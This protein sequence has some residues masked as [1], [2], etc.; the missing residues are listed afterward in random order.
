MAAVRLLG[1]VLCFFVTTHEE[2]SVIFIILQNLAGIGNAVL[3]IMQVSMLCEF[4]LKM[5]NAYS[6]PFG[7]SLW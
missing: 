4:G 7:E 2:H 3:K 1:F 6:R 5:P